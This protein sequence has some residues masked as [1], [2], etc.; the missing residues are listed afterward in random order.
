MS[1]GQRSRVSLAVELLGAPDLLVLD[2][3]TVGLDPLPR[4]VLWDL[5]PPCLQG[6][7]PSGDDLD[8]FWIAQSAVAVSFAVLVC[9]LTIKSSVWPLIA[10]ALSDALL[11]T[12]L[13]LL[14]SAFAPTEFQVVQFMPALLFP[15]ILCWPLPRTRWAW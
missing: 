8:N 4:V 11:G 5:F 6:D 14:V 2:E 15:Q 10:V 7:Q 1:G 12:T 9:G 3:P 13:G